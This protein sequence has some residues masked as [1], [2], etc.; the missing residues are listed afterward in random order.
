MKLSDCT[1]SHTH[2]RGVSARYITG[3]RAVTATEGSALLAEYVEAYG[4]GQAPAYLSP[5]GW[6][7][8][9]AA[10]KAKKAAVLQATAAGEA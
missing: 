1:L 5:A 2:C 7:A 10:P 3:D 9:E 8:L 4:P 6:Q